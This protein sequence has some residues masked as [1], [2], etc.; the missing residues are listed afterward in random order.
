MIA[1]P[2][3][4]IP[5]S[6]KQLSAE[7]PSVSVWSVTGRRV[8]VRLRRLIGRAVRRSADPATADVHRVF[9]VV[10]DDRCDVESLNDTAVPANSSRRT[11]LPPCRP[12]LHIGQ[13]KRVQSMSISN[14][15]AY[16]KPQYIASV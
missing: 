4:S 6:P 13:L 11:F 3:A 15:Q 14:S 10:G 12:D 5:N 2:R 1:T 7:I 8:A 9:V 16:D